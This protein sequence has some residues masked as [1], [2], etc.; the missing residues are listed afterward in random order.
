MSEEIHW[1]TRGATSLTLMLKGYDSEMD[2]Q[3]DLLRS[4]LKDKQFNLIAFQE[5]LKS[6][7]D[8]HD[9]LEHVRDEGILNYR[10]TFEILLDEQEAENVLAPIKSDHPL[11]MDFLRVAEPLA[12]HI[13]VAA[14]KDQSEENIPENNTDN[15]QAEEMRLRFVHRL[16]TLLQS[17][18]AID[19][20]NV[21]FQNID[22]A[23]S[24]ASDWTTLDTLSKQTISLIKT[25]LAEEKKQFEGYLSELNAKLTRIN[26]IVASDSATLLELKKLNQDFNISIN[27]QMADARAKIDKN[28]HVS[29]L[30]EELL[31]SLDSIAKRLESYQSS[32]GEKL[33]SL[34]RSKEEMTSHIQQLEKENLLLLTE[35]HK[36]RKISMQDALTQLPNRQGFSVR[37]EEEMSRAE[38]YKHF[39]S[40]AILD[41]DFFKKVNDNFGHL[42]GD[43]VL[44]M[45]A[46]EMKKNCR[47]SDFLARFGGEEF[48]LLLPQTSLEEAMIAVNKIRHH[49]E[50]RPFHF[51]NKP[52]PITISGGVAQR[53]P[54]EDIEIWLDRADAALY[55]S[56]RNGRNKI[57]AC[58]T[59]RAKTD[60]A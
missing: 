41:I 12:R 1:L 2:E 59:Q 43:R 42:V 51:Q 49:V 17:L 16:R 14:I 46:H 39:I 52:V 24:N 19:E 9:Q 4:T 60:S 18:T 33:Q 21:E 15:K 31:D 38:R 58:S 37:L 28:N 29:S 35:L 6:V 34:Q 50:T 36:E 56:K 23:L 3:L 27:G 30:K 55:E 10:R 48:V 32:Y 40:V 22:K 47:E 11:I 44:K 5:A 54:G 26:Q 57:T 8:L 45:I 20:Q 25:R 53:L 13:S 7:E